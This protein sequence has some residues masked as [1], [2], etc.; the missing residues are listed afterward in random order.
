MQD[1]TLRNR[2]RAIDECR[3]KKKKRR[4]SITFPRTQTLRAI[5]GDLTWPIL[6]L[7][8]HSA[9]V[10]LLDRFNFQH[11]ARKRH[12]GVATTRIYFQRIPFSRTPC[13][14]VERRE[15]YEKLFMLGTA[16]PSHCFTIYE[17]L[18]YPYLSMLPCSV[19]SQCATV[20][21]LKEMSK[22]RGSHRSNETLPHR[23]S[24]LT[25]LLDY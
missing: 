16:H 6:L 2:R 3:E 18:T 17:I 21:F 10:Q 9:L 4:G 20:C 7:H 24:S 15:K 8:D 25:T 23:P 22:E 12:K 1:A 5:R 19:N 14:S 11:K 13:A